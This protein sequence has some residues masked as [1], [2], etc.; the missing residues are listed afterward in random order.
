MLRC[1]IVLVELT[2]RDVLVA[3]ILKEREWIGHLG[4][5]LMQILLVLLLRQLFFA[6]RLEVVSVVLILVESDEKS[7]AE[8]LV[9]SAQASDIA[10]L[11]P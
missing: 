8:A 11:S 6:Q 5:R 9:G 7:L 3:R 4:S 1:S 10:R 2:L